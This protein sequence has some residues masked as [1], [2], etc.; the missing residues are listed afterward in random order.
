M[1][2]IFGCGGEDVTE[3]LEFN[4]V[5]NGIFYK[6]HTDV[7][8]FDS[9][10]SVYRQ[11]ILDNSYVRFNPSIFEPRGKMQANFLRNLLH[12]LVQRSESSQSY[13][14]KCW[15]PYIQMALILFEGELSADLKSAQAVAQ[16]ILAGTDAAKHDPRLWIAYVMIELK[17]TP[18]TSTKNALKILTK[19]LSTVKDIT[20]R[21]RR[22]WV[23]LCIIAVKLLCG[24]PILPS[25]DFTIRPDLSAK[26]KQKALH[27]ICCAVEGEYFPFSEKGKHDHSCMDLVSKERYESAYSRARK[28]LIGIHDNKYDSNDYFDST[29]TWVFDVALQVWLEVLNPNE[30]G[31]HFQFGLRCLDDWFM[32]EQCSHNLHMSQ[33]I[34]CVLQLYLELAV[35]QSLLHGNE[36]MSACLKPI[37]TTAISILNGKTPTPAFLLS[38]AVFENESLPSKYSF[39]DIILSNFDCSGTESF[40]HVITCVMK[41]LT[42]IDLQANYESNEFEAMCSNWSTGKINEVRRALLRA[43]SCEYGSSMPCFWRALIR[44]ELIGGSN[45]EG[46]GISKSPTRAFLAARTIFERGISYCVASKVLW[47][48]AFTILRPAFSPEELSRQLFV[49]EEKGIRLIQGHEEIS[50]NDS[51]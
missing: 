20:G 49:L 26:S 28:N 14:V 10:K 22:G 50:Y 17:K 36:S 39:S 51:R 44:L 11:I 35:V 16:Q 48:D 34:M 4:E 19:A 15:S 42:T 2:S 9:Q 21:Q 8:K 32:R 1:S 37:L 46:G 18:D 38:L 27:I 45:V 31:L 13:S 30:S 29:P 23:E 40:F 43:V 7:K 6:G 24:L 33:G 12:S 47:L 3:T 5:L 41:Y 25:S